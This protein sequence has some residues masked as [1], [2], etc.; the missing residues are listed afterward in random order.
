MRCSPAVEEGLITLIGATTEN[1]LRGQLGAAQPGAA[2]RARSARDLRSRAGDPRGETALG[3]SLSQAI[4]TLIAQRAGGDARNALSIL[5][6]SAAT[7][8]GGP[9]TEANVEDAARK[10]R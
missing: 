8:G 3:V 2:V 7:A 5:E 10:R 1:L 9:V 4:R 6:A